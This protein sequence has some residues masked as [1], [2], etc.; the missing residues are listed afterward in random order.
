MRE[1]TLC[2]RLMAGGGA[3]P[4]GSGK[5]DRGAISDSIMRNLQD[6]LNSRA[7]CCETRRDYGMPDFNDL[8]GGF[9]D[10]LPTIARSIRTQI[11]NFEPRL[12]GAT[13]RHVPDPTNP[14]SLSFQISVT[15]TLED[16]A[17]RMSFQ[18]DLGDDGKLRVR[19]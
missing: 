12:S 15:L 4:A 19:G 9:P 13:V 16:G 6:V 10:A 5:V 8:A 14:L 2:E 1:R 18:T 3:L 7:G 17:E 11:E